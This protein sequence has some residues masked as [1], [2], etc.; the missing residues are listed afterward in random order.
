V[1][2]PREELQSVFHNFFT[3]CQSGLKAEGEHSKI[4]VNIQ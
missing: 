1:A 2:G 4:S 3:R